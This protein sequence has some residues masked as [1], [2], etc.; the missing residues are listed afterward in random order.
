MIVES[1]EQNVERD[2]VRGLLPF[3]TL[4][5]PDHAIEKGRAGSSGDAHANPIGQHL[6]AAGHG[7][8]I[9]TRLA[10]DRSQFT[11]DRRFIDR[12]DAFNDL[13]VGR[14]QIAGFDKNNVADL[15]RGAGNQLEILRAR[16]A[17]QLGFC[18]GARAPQ[19]IGLRLSASL[20]D[21]LGKI[22]EQHG[23]PQPHDDLKFEHDLTAAGHEISDQND[24][25]QSGDDLKHEHHWVLDQRA[26]I[27]LHERLADRRDHNLGVHQSRHRHALANLRGFHR[28]NSE[29][30]SIRTRC[31]RA[32][33]VARR[34]DRARAPGR[35]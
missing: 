34:A 26:R 33:S 17:Q 19:G 28:N 16:T 15:E 6:R 12:S 9:A 13:A 22:G 31:R 1:R 20:G 8:A 14:N 35:R 2:L 29:E 4:H 10:D 21:G 3:G 11:G 5:Q 30:N 7:R 18:F 23:K 27:E 32:S 25:G 24:G